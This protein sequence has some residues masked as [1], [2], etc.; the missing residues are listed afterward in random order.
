MSLIISAVRKLTDV[1]LQI[2]RQQCR[3][4]NVTSHTLLPLWQIQG[5]ISGTSLLPLRKKT[6]CSDV[7]KRISK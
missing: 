1:E 7:C 6:T 5:V 2:N 4:N 3:R